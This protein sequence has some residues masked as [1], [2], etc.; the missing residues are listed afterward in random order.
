MSHIPNFSPQPIPQGTLLDLYPDSK[1]L[2]GTDLMRNVNKQKGKLDEKADGVG[3]I[4][5]LL[6]GSNGA[7]LTPLH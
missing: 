2:K 1:V 7:K 3:G 5:L 4:F 6:H